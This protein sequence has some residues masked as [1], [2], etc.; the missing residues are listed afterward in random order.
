MFA[1]EKSI[2]NIATF[3]EDLFA[4]VYGTEQ[5]AEILQSKLY[6][7]DCRCQ[8]VTDLTGQKVDTIAALKSLEAKAKVQAVTTI[9]MD[10]VEFIFDISP[11]ILESQVK[12]LN[13]LYPR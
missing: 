11:E 5:Q 7:K 1:M 12:H 9:F 3:Y 8:F 10:S 4:I 6:L 13:M 2:F